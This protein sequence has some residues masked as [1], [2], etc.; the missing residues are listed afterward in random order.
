MKKLFV[1]FMILAVVTIFGA[2]V[3]NWAIYEE[4]KTL[5]VWNHYGPAATVWNSYVMAGKYGALYTYSDVRFDWIPG[6]AA[7][8]PKKYQEGEYW[9]YEIPLRK[10]VKWSDGTPFTADDVVFTINTVLKLIK[11]YG[12]GGNWASM[13]DPDFVEKAEKV[14]DYTVKIYFKKL[15]LAK[16]EFGALM[17]IIVQKKFW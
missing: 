2:K 3:I 15:G 8:M 16:V 7:D 14:D 17:G 10:D 13:Y 4:P 1:L 9:V 5:N 11:E 6:L 12:L